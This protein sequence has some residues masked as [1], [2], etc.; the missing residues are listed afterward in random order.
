[1]GTN[2]DRRVDAGDDSGFRLLLKKKVSCVFN[3]ALSFDIPLNEPYA[4][5][6]YGKGITRS[7]DPFD[8]GDH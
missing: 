5:P 4:R 1:M 3:E 2:I 7:G 6:C 8:I